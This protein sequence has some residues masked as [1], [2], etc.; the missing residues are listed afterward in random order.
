MTL[1]PLLLFVAF[2]SA[3]SSNSITEVVQEVE[4][5]NSMRESLV[6]AVS[7][8][9]VDQNTFKQVCAPVGKEAKRVAKD[10]GWK[11][12]QASH[13]PRNPKHKAQGLEKSAIE[14]MQKDSSLQAFWLKDNGKQH[15]FRR[16]PVQSACLHCHGP[17]DKRPDFIKSKYPQDK[18]FNF[19]EGDLRGIYHVEVSGS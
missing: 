19:K 6:G 13:K 8:G 4:R 5:I 1:S 9:K 18:A 2:S 15:Y 11:F 12:R 10:K 7:S 3:Q 14:K 17:K 16:I